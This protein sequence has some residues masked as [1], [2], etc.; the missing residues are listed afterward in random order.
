MEY[1]KK[2]PKNKPFKQLEDF[3][4]LEMYPNVKKGNAQRSEHLE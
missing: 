1:I 4:L 2:N 3:M